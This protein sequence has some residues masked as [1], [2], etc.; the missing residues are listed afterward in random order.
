[1][2]LCY[3][4]NKA[5]T[6]RRHEQGRW[7][8]TVFQREQARTASAGGTPGLNRRQGRGSEDRAG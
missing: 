7:A 4:P 5:S 8:V 3:E 1:M 6:V 2:G